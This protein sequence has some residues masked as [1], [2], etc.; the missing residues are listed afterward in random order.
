VIV[1]VVCAV[2]AALFAQAVVRLRRRGRTDLAGW[3]RV[4]C[5]AAGIV[6]LP[7]A[8]LALHERAEESLPWHMT[9]HVLAGDL[10]PALLVLATR[11][12]LALFL[13]PA[14]V[15]GPLARSPLRT[16]LSFLLRPRVTFVVWAV[17]LLV[18]HLPATYDA[19]V[20]HDLVHYG[21]HYCFTLAGLLAWTVLLDDRRTVATRVA[22]G[23]AMFATGTLLADVLMF[24]FRALYAPY[25]DV[26]EQ[27]WAGLVMVVEQVLTLGTLLFV[28]LRPRLRAAVT[29]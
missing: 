4:A 26:A 10:A 22:L 19:A 17:S 24:S 8:L 7:W 6:V 20:R 9:Q 14:P 3:S 21:Q 29:A 2:A 23:G 12:P 16:L 11:G 1:V 15:L 27:Q 28:L 25:P 13:L 18:W 5:F